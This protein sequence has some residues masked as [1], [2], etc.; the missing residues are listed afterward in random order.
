MKASEKPFSSFSSSSSSSSACVFGT[1][2]ER[3]KVCSKEGGGK[4]RWGGDR[5]EGFFTRP[6]FPSHVVR[7]IWRR[8]RKK[9]FFPLLC[10]TSGRVQFRVYRAFLVRQNAGESGFLKT[11]ISPIAI[12]YLP[13]PFIKP[14]EGQTKI[15]E[16]GRAD[17]GCV[18]W[19]GDAH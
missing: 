10:S 14:R 13:G 3:R 8:R 6:L 16:L 12:S 4:A 18:L 17:C 11:F 5:S 15:L 1:R 7:P 2:W 19:A 9:N